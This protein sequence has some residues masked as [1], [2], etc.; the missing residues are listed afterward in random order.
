MRV[1]NRSML[2]L[3]LFVI[4]ESGDVTTLA[5]GEGPVRD[6]PPSSA[7]LS[8]VI[9]PT[10]GFN[11]WLAFDIHENE[12]NVLSN[13]EG[14]V[15]TGLSS[16]GYTLVALDGGWQGGRFKNGTVYSNASA[17]PSG[18]LS[19][20]RKIHALNLTFGIYTDRGQSTCDAHVGSAGF[21]S[22][23]AAYYASVEAD[24]LKEDSCDATQSHAGALAQFLLMQNA[25]AA[26]G[27]PFVFSL[28]GWLKWYSG[29]ASLASVGTSWRVG[30]DALNWQNVLMNMDAAA[31][32]SAFVA[33]GKFVD[34]DEVMGPSRGR[35]INA[36]RTLTQFAFIAVVG[37]PLLLSFDLTGRNATDVEVAPFLN[38]EILAVHWDASPSGPSFNRI[39]GG[40]LGLDRTTPLTHVSCTSTAAR[41]TFTPSDVHVPTGV[42]TGV[43]AARAAP[44]LCLMAGAAW[45][46]ECNNAQAVWLGT[47]ADSSGHSPNCCAGKAGSN[48][49]NCTNQLLTINADGT[50]TTPYWPYNNNAAGP[51][52]S[53]DSPTPNSVFFEERLNDTAGAASQQWRWDATTGTLADTLGT[54]VGAA[55][56]ENSNI[57][58]RRLEGGEV[59]LLFINNSPAL[60][61]MSCDHSCCA[62][63]GLADGATLSVRDLFLHTDNGTV[64]CVGTGFA[65]DVPAGGSSVFVRVSPR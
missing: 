48:L 45:Y 18:L 59:A 34:V 16:K 32:A 57:W 37:S 49:G 42:A 5:P 44:G 55:P 61:A 41:W 43:F 53:L 58:A 10:R 20:S 33:P 27:R 52:L 12:T 38:D 19:L 1:R 3:L 39:V 21:E 25:L 14:L 40:Q 8:G 11:T 54:C 63:A 26:T 7:P 15:A 4:T 62:A 64:S 30:P 22:E 56:K 23:D 35:P 13:A 17:F 60:M 6:V 47:C 50:I 28:C 65:F 46:K 29:S 24:F 31:D 2:L 36:S 9:L 51:Y